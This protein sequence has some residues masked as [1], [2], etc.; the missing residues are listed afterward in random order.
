MLDPR[1]EGLNFTT[2]LIKVENSSKNFNG[3][4][5]PTRE[6]VESKLLDLMD[7]RCS[8][9]DAA[10]WAARWVV[11]DFHSEVHDSGH[12]VIESA[13]VLRTVE[14]LSAADLKTSA[15]SYLYDEVDFQ[16][17]LEELRRS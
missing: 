16:N 12:S 1:W 10:S 15:H 4:V 7:R 17:W 11:K 2:Y 13:V 14:S 9:E 5:A 6:Q 8:R 3:R